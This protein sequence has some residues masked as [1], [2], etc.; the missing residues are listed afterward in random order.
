VTLSRKRLKE[1]RE[2]AALIEKLGGPSALAKRLNLKTNL[3]A[4]WSARGIAWQ[5]RNAVAELAARDG[6]TVPE[7][8]VISAPSEAA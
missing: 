6:L 4:N 8:F 5:W 7:G 1:L 2:H 3:V